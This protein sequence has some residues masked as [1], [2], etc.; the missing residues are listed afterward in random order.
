MERQSY[1]RLILRALRSI[2]E[3]QTEPV[4][5]DADDNEPNGANIQWVKL[6]H[7]S[8]HDFLTDEARSGPYF[9]DKALFGGKVFC[10]ILELATIKELRGC[11]R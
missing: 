7:R 9:I 4:F 3:I 10:R 11:K 1:V 2:T 5:D 6:S 8:F